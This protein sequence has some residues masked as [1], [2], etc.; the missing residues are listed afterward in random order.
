MS[1]INS[2][3]SS[4]PTNIYAPPEA[5]VDDVIPDGEIALADRGARFVAALIDGILVGALNGFLAYAVGYNIFAPKTAPS[6]ATQVLLMLSGIALMMLINGYLLAKNG[7]TVGKKLMSIKIVRTDGSKATIQRIVGM[8]L[9]PVWV[10]SAI[11]FAGAIVTLVDV[12][13]IFRESRKCLHDNI[14]D[15]I[16]AKA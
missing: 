16:V 6:V 12:L 8:R 15:T 7:Q 3:T 4:T 14:A 11:P 2:T 10:V 5:I 1:D 9:L 13:F